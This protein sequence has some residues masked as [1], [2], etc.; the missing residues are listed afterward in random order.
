[1]IITAPSIC[2]GLYLKGDEAGV[3]FY[4]QM[5]CERYPFADKIKLCFGYCSVIHRCSENA[6]RED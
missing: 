1:M 5:G 4:Q 2:W 6:F 3:L